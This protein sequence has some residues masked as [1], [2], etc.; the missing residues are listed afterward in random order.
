M[1]RM[2][3]VRIPVAVD[4]QGHWYAC[5]S[6]TGPNNHDEL[7]EVTDFDCVGPNEA[8]YWVTAELAVPDISDVVGEVEQAS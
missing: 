5:G 8:L 2:I 1:A 7:L 4:T 6:T 3:K